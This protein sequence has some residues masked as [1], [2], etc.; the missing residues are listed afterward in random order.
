MIMSRN[1][2][3]FR[4][5]GEDIIS[6]LTVKHINTR[7]QISVGKKYAGKTVRIHEYPDGSLLL[8]PVEVISEFE[9]QLL[10]DDAFQDRLDAFERWKSEHTSLSVRG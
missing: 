6:E 2:Y 4:E 8:I 1:C 10:K 7:G 5:V 9:L 3:N